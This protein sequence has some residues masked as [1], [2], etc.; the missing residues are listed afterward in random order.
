MTK[1][2]FWP[3][4]LAAVALASMPFVARAQAATPADSSPVPGWGDLIES[5]RTL[6]ERML[7]RLPEDQRADPQV[8]QEVARL[9]LESM[10]SS[11]IAAIGAD[12]DHPQFLPA[13]GQVLNVG[14]PNADTI[15]RSAVITP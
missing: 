3:L 6:P 2:R 8:R 4:G 1:S 5:L 7:A 15:Y 10:A 9:A 13:I 12:G 14:Q 11:A